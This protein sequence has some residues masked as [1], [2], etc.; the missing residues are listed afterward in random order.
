[1]SGHWENGYWIGQKIDGYPS[2]YFDSGTFKYPW[3]KSSL[4]D[5]KSSRLSEAVTS[6]PKQ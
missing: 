6:V 1:M 3:Q 2:T 4:E 5:S